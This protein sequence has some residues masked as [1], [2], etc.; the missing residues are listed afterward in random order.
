MASEQSELV[1]SMNNSPRP[2]VKKKHNTK[3]VLKMSCLIEQAKK[4]SCTIKTGSLISNKDVTDEK[5]SKNK[6]DDVYQARSAA[7]NISVVELTW[8]KRHS[9][10]QCQLVWL[11]KEADGRIWNNRQ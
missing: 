1:D 2:F 3:K 6:Y 8:K 5:R 10:F 7:L 11:S 9:V 4:T